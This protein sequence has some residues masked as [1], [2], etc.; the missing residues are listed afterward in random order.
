MNYFADV[1][2]TSWTVSLLVIPVVIV[3]LV[4]VIEIFI[5]IGTL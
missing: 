1:F 4:I 2:I 5:V 3:T